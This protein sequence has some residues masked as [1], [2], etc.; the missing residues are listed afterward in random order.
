M[1]WG[2]LGRTNERGGAHQWD[3]AHERDGPRAG[4]QF[5]VAGRERENDSVAHYAHYNLHN[6]AFEVNY[7]Y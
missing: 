5:G 2:A 3:G 4:A 7:L 6:C 1:R